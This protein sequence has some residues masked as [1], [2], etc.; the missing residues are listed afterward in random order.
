MAC[1][2]LISPDLPLSNVLIPADVESMRTLNN[3]AVKKGGSVTIP[4][5]YEE[6]YKGN[7]KYWCSGITWALCSIVAY[8]NSSG[9]TSVMDH[10]GQ[11]LFT[12]E[13]SSVSNSG[14]HWCAAE[15]GSELIPDDRNYLY[16]TVSQ[17]KP[18][19]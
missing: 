1:G 16:L 18:L 19:E 6:Q 13:L 11:N 15:I 12:V 3:V 4:C 14:V 10:P 7:P 17:G 9:S 2:F 5:L 8:A